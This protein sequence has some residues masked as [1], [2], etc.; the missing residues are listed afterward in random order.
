MNRP[1]DLFALCLCCD[2]AYAAVWHV[3]QNK[4]VGV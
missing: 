4:G 3:D 1:V 2:I